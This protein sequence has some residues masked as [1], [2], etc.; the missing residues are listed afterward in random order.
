MS[1]YS[2][3][4]ERKI[5]K[6]DHFHQSFTL[7]PKIYNGFI[8]LFEDRNPLHTDQTFAQEKGFESEVMFGN[9]LNGFISYFV[10]ECLP[11]KNVIIQT[12]EIQYTKPVYLNDHLVLNAEVVD[13]HESVNT[14]ELKFHFTKKDVKVARGKIQIGLLT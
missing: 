8:D 2:T 7:T 9:I 12:Q 3:E 5:E 4:T 1:C 14:V 10:G 13:V 11:S 6:G